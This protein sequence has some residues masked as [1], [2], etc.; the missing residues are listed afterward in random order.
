MADKP[1]PPCNGTIKDIQSQEKPCETWEFCLPFG[2]RL[3]YAGGCITHTAPKFPPADGT[4]GKIII[5]D[6]CIVG[7]EKDDIPLY[8]AA[9]CAPVP[10]PCECAEADTGSALP[11][12]SPTAGNLF[13]Y[14]ASDRPLVKV[15]IEGGA[16]ISVT[17]NGT[18]QDPFIIA[19]NAGQGETS[20]IFIQ[21]TNSSITVA[22]AGTQASPFT[23]THR[24]GFTG[25]AGNGLTFDNGHLTDY[26]PPADYT[27]K[28]TGIVPGDGI[29]VR[30][31]TTNGIATVSVATVPEKNNGIFTW[32]G[33]NVEMINNRIQSFERVITTNAETLTMGNVDIELNEFGSVAAVTKYDYPGY[34]FV[35]Q[36]N[37]GTET[38]QL[39]VE[40]PVRHSGMMMLEFSMEATYE[41]ATGLLMYVNG[42]RV[43]NRTR[44]TEPYKKPT[45][46]PGEPETDPKL[47]I[48]S[49]GLTDFVCTPGNYTLIIDL[50]GDMDFP[51][52]ANAMLVMRL[53][54]PM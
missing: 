2:G 21:S 25:S 12:P 39:V 29:D 17:G 13:A 14:D 45:V 19:S 27:G 35:R 9:P 20:G 34:V 49:F 5:A 31:D 52:N 48:S 43:N 22:G 44:I 15:R 18:L 37:Y 4:Y 47:Y 24:E 1:C 42:A 28:I 51:L 33:Y 3:S 30:M 50:P 54:Q 7:V 23:L 38:K 6:G 36:F 46:S 10:T 11:D 53:V 8:N 40:V 41:Y 16:N 32:G 26:T